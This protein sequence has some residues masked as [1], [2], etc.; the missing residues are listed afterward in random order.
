MKPPQLPIPWFLHLRDEARQSDLAD[1]SVA[2][3]EERAHA[4][5][6]SG[7]GHRQCSPHRVAPDSVLASSGGEGWS[8]VV[9]GRVLLDS[10]EDGSK[11]YRDECEPC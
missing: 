5:D 6:E 8:G 9:A 3:V 1:E 10:G 4:S 2:D 7:P 11:E